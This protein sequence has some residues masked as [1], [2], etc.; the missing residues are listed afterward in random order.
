MDFDAN[1]AV[2]TALS[3]KTDLERAEEARFQASQRAKLRLP[4][5]LELKVELGR[6][7]VESAVSQ[8]KRDPTDETYS[9]FAEGLALQGEYREAAELTRSPEARAA[10]A[11]IVDAF[12]NPRDCGCPQRLN[13]LPT[14]FKKETVIVEGKQVD[15]I[16][17]SLC[18]HIR[19]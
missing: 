11:A 1:L 15:I 13:N 7:I 3:R 10:Y 9:R 8:M 2:E 17:C 18:G 12:D 14:Q 4:T 6:R 16:G 19:C 5:A